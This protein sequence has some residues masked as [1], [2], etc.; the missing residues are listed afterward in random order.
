VRLREQLAGFDA[1][2]PER[3]PALLDPLPVV[4]DVAITR[5]EGDDVHGHTLLRGFDAAEHRVVAPRAGRNIAPGEVWL[6]EVQGSK[7]STAE[8]HFADLGDVR[9]TIALPTGEWLEKA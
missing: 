4:V 1:L 3:L 7:R 6:L 8:Q 5:V 2:D 9:C